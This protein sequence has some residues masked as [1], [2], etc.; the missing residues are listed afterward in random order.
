VERPSA[1]S[2]ESVHASFLPVVVEYPATAT[3]VFTHPAGFEKASF[4]RAPGIE[5]QVVY[6]VENDMYYI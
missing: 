5:M 1:F 4:P 6:H 3:A 2:C